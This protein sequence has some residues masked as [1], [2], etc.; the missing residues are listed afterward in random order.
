MLVGCSGKAGVAYQIVSD[1]RTEVVL[2]IQCA[3]LKRQRPNRVSVEEEERR[4]G[5][6]DCTPHSA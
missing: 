3:P 5:T 6:L 2:C 4:G 1:G